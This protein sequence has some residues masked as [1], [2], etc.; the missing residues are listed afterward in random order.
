VIL[1]W[2]GRVFEFPPHRATIV[3]GLEDAL[4][5]YETTVAFGKAKR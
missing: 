4:P 2:V 5:R 1:C 3:V